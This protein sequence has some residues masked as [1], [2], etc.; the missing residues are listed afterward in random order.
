[1]AHWYQTFNHAKAAYRQ[2]TGLS[3][4]QSSIDKAPGIYIYLHRATIF[5]KWVDWYFVGTYQEWSDNYSELPYS[6]EDFRLNP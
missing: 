1:M 4:E 5:G 6:G 3:Y 2:K